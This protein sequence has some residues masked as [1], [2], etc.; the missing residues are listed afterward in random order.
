MP[1]VENSA[2]CAKGRPAWPG[3][4]GARRARTRPPKPLVARCCRQSW[5]VLAAAGEPPIASAGTAYYPR[6]PRQ[7]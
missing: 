6:R 7:H 3:G 5:P 1:E 2:I 4:G